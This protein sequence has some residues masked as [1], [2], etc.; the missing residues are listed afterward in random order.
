MKRVNSRDSDFL[1][2]FIDVLSTSLLFYPYNQ[3]SFFA[4]TLLL[5][6]KSLQISFKV[7]GKIVGY[8]SL[9]NELVHLR[10][11]FI[12]FLKIFQGSYISVAY[13]FGLGNFIF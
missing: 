4:R 6:F 7:S 13:F 5:K 8:P 2:S 12:Y 9:Y 3:Y 10:I 11:K 1:I